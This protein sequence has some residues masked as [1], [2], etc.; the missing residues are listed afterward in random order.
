MLEGMR[1]N[2]ADI[3][4]RRAL[5]CGWINPD[6]TNIDQLK[7]AIRLALDIEVRA[8]GPYPDFGYVIETVNPDSKNQLL[9]AGYSLESYPK[10]T[11]QCR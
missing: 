11:H 8:G 9:A 7:S 4:I 5:N 3:V 2:R 10:G 6:T 1:I